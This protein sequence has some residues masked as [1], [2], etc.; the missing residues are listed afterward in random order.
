MKWKDKREV[1]MLSTIHDD[2]MIDKKRR[3]K[4]GGG[5]T[6]VIKKPKVIEDYNQQ[7]NSVDRS[8]QMV[9]YYGYGHR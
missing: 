8:D 9:L 7:M 1:N 6:E 4:A 5:G 3:T 2:G